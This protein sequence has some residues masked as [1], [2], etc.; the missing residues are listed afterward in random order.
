MGS[1]NHDAPRRE[2]GAPLVQPGA[3]RALTKILH[4]NFP[5]MT[6][7]QAAQLASKIIR[8]LHREGMQMGPLA[9]F[10]PSEMSRTGT[11]IKRDPFEGFDEVL[12]SLEERSPWNS[13]ELR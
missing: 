13:P 10:G 12:A 8:S 9:T 5:R 2:S 11:P 6:S 1:L 3:I 7:E 4:M